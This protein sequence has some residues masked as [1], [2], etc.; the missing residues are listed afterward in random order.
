[1]AFPFQNVWQ[2]HKPNVWHVGLRNSD[3][4]GVL[5][6]LIDTEEGLRRLITGMEAAALVLGAGK[7]LLYI[8]EYAHKEKEWIEKSR[9]CS[10][11]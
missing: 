9:E 1:M 6:R 8:P 4:F 3:Q 5:L 7:K 11:N 2:R 10:R